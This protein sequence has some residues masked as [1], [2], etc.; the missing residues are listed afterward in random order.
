MD[1]GAFEIE[2]KPTLKRLNALIEVDCI[3]LID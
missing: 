3:I 2:L 1:D